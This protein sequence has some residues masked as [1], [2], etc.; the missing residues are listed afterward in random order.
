MKT[1]Q[2]SILALGTC[3][4]L[5]STGCGGPKPVRGEDVAGFDDEAMST[6]LDKRDLQ[7]LLHENMQALQGSA[8]LKRWES[9]NRACLSTG[10]VLIPT[11]EAPTAANS[12]A[13]S[14][15]WQAS[16]VHPGVLSL[17]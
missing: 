13:R 16:F 11:R 12:A 3:V 1:W 17:G 8:L 7:K 4:A 14:R 5:L 15:K 10:S 9:E 6:G 2:Y